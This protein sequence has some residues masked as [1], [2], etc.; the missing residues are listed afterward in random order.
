MI[1]C[2]GRCLSGVSGLHFNALL[3]TELGQRLLNAQGGEAG[4]PVGI[5]AFPHDLSHH[6][7]SLNKRWE[8]KSN[9]HHQGETDRNCQTGEASTT[10]ASKWIITGSLSSFLWLLL[11]LISVLLTSQMNY[12]PPV[13][14]KI[15]QLLVQLLL[16]IVWFDFFHVFVIV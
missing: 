10:T 2:Q 3:L 5:P 1:R 16:C 13:I 15:V 11:L 14:K 7:Q 12:L 9:Q 8:K 6:P 4:C